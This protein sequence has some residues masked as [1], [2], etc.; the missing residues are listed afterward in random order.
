MMTI[1]VFDTPITDAKIGTN[2][3]CF[4]VHPSLHSWGCP[5]SES[6]RC[7]TSRM[8]GRAAAYV[9]STRRLRAKHGSS[10][11]RVT[12]HSVRSLQTLDNISALPMEQER[13]ADCSCAPEL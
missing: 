3:H 7:A 6:D 8:L 11:H 10:G 1:N 4:C 2:K 13:V 9:A 12:R 5:L